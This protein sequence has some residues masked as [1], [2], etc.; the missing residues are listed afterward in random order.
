MLKKIAI[1]LLA[2]VS[3]VFIYAP[4]RP[5]VYYIKRSILIDAPPEKIFD[6]LNDVRSWKLWFTIPDGVKGTYSD[7]STGKGAFFTYE[8]SLSTG[9]GKSTITKS[10][11]PSE[12][13][14]D[15]DMTKPFGS[16]HTIEYTIKTKDNY[17]EVT[18]LMIHRNNY[19]A[20]LIHIFVDIDGFIGPLIERD[21][22]KLKQLAEK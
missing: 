2:L 17:T 19:I 18:W 12:I 1:A 6:Y 4:F 11:R 3:M 7:P 10:V 5:D 15:L 20:K 21:L 9:S 16:Y 14:I 13:A 8:G 22:L